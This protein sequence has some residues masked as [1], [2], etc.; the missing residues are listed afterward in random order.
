MLVLSLVYSFCLRRILRQLNRA[1]ATE[2]HAHSGVSVVAN[3][4]TPITR[5]ARVLF[6]RPMES[7]AHLILNAARRSAR[8]MA[9]AAS[10]ARGIAVKKGSRAHLAPSAVT[11]VATR[12]AFAEAMPSVKA[13][14]VR[15]RLVRSAARSTVAEPRKP[16]SESS[17]FVFYERGLSTALDFRSMKMNL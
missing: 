3:A 9:V 2:R 17:G 11:V 13:M 6:V 10:R 5:A 15:A 7:P 14:G 8:A 1:V 16:A 4:A 12:T